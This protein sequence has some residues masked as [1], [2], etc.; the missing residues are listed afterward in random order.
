[1]TKRLTC[2]QVKD[3]EALLDSLPKLNSGKRS[4]KSV[5]TKTDKPR[6]QLQSEP[7]TIT[8][9]KYNNA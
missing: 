5:R 6:S 9:K 8:V 3:L 7:E 4:K 1:M 2:K